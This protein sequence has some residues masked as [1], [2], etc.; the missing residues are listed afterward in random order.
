MSQHSHIKKRSIQIG[1]RQTSVALEEEFWEGLKEIARERQLSLNK[2]LT[3]INERR[4][5]ANLSSTIRLHVL[6]HYQES[7]ERGRDC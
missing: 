4:T 5:H 3:D 1:T 6:K 2:L 7:A